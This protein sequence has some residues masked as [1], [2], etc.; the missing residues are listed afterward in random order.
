MNDKANELN[1]NN[2]C[3]GVGPLFDECILIHAA[4]TLSVRYQSGFGFN[5]V[6][7]DDGHIE[8]YVGDYRP[9][10]SGY[11]IRT[12][13]LDEVK[14]LCEAGHFGKAI[15]VKYELMVDSLKQRTW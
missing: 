8:L 13:S 6:V 9:G 5:Y 3:G 10:K 2:T 4:A 7:G 12:I 15:F 11:D 1:Q 14:K